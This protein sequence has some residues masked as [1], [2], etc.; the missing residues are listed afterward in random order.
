MT[1][2]PKFV[3][4][5]V[6]TE[7]S[8]SEG[9]ARIKEL[10]TEAHS[11]GMPAVAMTDINNLYAAVKFYRACLNAG[12]KPLFGVELTLGAVT[13][14]DPGGKIILLCM[15][16]RGFKGVSELLTQL[17][18]QPREGREL[19]AGL[20]QIESVADDVI[21]LTGFDGAIGGLIR[22]GHVSESMQAAEKTGS[23]I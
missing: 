6:H 12:V 8:L 2:S 7:Y 20:N 17:Y 16:N 5:N 22:S 19:V 9:I 3:H 11:A 4:L 14:V 23:G 1:S 13:P 10:A 18:T 21:A 15:N